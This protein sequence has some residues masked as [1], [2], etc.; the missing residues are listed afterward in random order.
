MSRMDEV[1]KHAL[2]RQPEPIEWN[3]DEQPAA[4]PL[5]V[6]ADEAAAGLPH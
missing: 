3:Y 6:D 5:D 1:L 2:V 4:P